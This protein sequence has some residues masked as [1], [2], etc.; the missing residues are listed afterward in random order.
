MTL[1]Q[2]LTR[3]VATGK[4]KITQKLLNRACRESSGKHRSKPPKLQRMKPHGFARSC[5]TT[6]VATLTLLICLVTG[7]VVRAAQPSESNIS[8]RG[9]SAAALFNRANSC[10]RDGKTGL[11]ILN[12]E[13][14]QL[15]AP[16]DADIAANLHFVRAKAGLPDASENWLTRSLTCVRPNTMAWLGS[17]GLVLVG[18]SIL[19]VRLYPQRR[20]ALRSS[21]FAGALLAASAIANAIVMWPKANEAVV[22]VRDAPALTSPVL[23]AEPLFKF[24]EGETVTVRAEH[25]DFELVQTS[26]GR[27]GWVG[28]ADLSRVVPQSSDR[29]QPPNR[30]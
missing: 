9:Y 19:L 14:A 20:L 8:T 16:T 13:R 25:K 27:S 30:T 5:Y 6:L 18:M 7:H 22:I 24:R 3:G 12:Y 17:F 28:R 21:T 29:S 15:L 26:T 11:A 4:I 23:A 10:A 1:F 2:I